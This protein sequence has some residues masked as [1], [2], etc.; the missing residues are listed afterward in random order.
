MHQLLVLN[1]TPHLIAQWV[2]S[3]D[4]E[5]STT[6][7]VTTKIHLSCLESIKALQHSMFVP[8]PSALSVDILL[9]LEL[10]GPRVKSIKALPYLPSA[11]FQFN[12]IYIFQQIAHRVNWEKV[13]SC[14]RWDLHITQCV[15]VLDKINPNH[16]EW[17]VKITL[18]AGTRGFLHL[19]Y[20]PQFPRIFVRTWILWINMECPPRAIV[21]NPLIR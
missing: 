1:N 5:W 20:R 8:T 21:I 18:N 7:M 13:T 15:L 14:T 19:K 16:V 2:L 9:R 12:S 4:N 6:L 11:Q 3:D 10:I 17:R